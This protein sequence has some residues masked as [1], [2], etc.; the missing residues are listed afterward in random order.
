MLQK[1]PLTVFSDGEQTRD[2]VNVN[3][4]VQVNIIAANRVGVSGAFNIASG[5][6]ITINRPVEM[7]TKENGG[8][9]K[10]EYGRKGQVMFFI[11]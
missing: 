5:K 7:L 1:E 3:D 2:F 6:R 8:N 4:V 10:I 9:C 11:V